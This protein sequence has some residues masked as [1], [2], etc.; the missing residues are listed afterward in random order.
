[1]LSAAARAAE[2]GSVPLALPPGAA[3][4]PGPDA[5]GSP[6]GLW[7]GGPGRLQRLAL[8]ADG[9][10]GIARTV[11]LPS[12]AVPVALAEDVR[13]FYVVDAA[14]AVLLAFPRVGDALGVPQRLPVGPAPTSVTVGC[15]VCTAAS[16][17]EYVAVANSGSGDLSVYT[18]DDE[19]PAGSTSFAA[20]RRVAVGGSPAAA[21]QAPPDGDRRLAVAGG[22]AGTV[23]V[24]D[25]SKGF[26]SVAD[27]KPGG[28]VSDVAWADVSGERSSSW[29]P[30]DLV[31]SDAS[32][33]RVLVFPHSDSGFADP[34]P[35]D[36][37]GP[38]AT[39]DEV[40]V[41]DLNADGHDDI[42]VAD[43]A[44]RSLVVFDG[45]GR[46]QFAAGRTI[47]TGIDPA[48]LSAGDWGGDWQHPDLAVADASR[49][50]VLLLL[51][52]GDAQVVPGV[53]ARNLTADADVLAWS[54]RTTGNVHRLAARRGT[55][56]GDIPVAAS[57]KPFDARVGRR[58]PGRPVIA[59]VACRNGRCHPYTW[60]LRARRERAISISV[61]TGCRLGAVAVWD[62]R[63]AYDLWAPTKRCPR[64]AAGVWVRT[65]R[66]PP[67]RRGSGMLGDMRNGYIAWADDSVRAASLS[68]K[69]RTVMTSGPDSHVSLEHPTITGRSVVYGVNNLGEGTGG[70][71][72]FRLRLDRRR[73]CQQVFSDPPRMAVPQPTGNADYAVDGDSVF[74]TDPDGVGHGASRG[75]FQV[76]P[77]RERWKTDC[78][79]MH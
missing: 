7:L 17:Q 73:A 30:S 33:A 13:F 14:N 69:R 10:M 27:L 9:A 22:K 74:Y 56:T 50:E 12:G 28:V 19:S 72:L 66:R 71:D 31:V 70:I 29:A 57:S 38:G 48:A 46:G 54:H 24:L 47:R 63:V 45:L 76:D 36:L 78:R 11:V 41:A 49:H 52:P 25:A 26:A 67:V 39:A 42:V 8:G 75:I 20:E 43:R 3:L 32:S 51:T 1:M 5:N 6:S 4:L 64:H 79:L 37:P 60:D 44:S 77:G 53:D 65:G 55:V 59:Y 68:G 16:Q 34:R 58:A 15:S 35:L 18:W 21:R 2:Y 40:A 23:T 62:N 61:A